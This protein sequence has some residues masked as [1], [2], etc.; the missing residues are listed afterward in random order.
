M[1]YDNF[2]TRFVFRKNFLKRAKARIETM[3]RKLNRSEFNDI[4]DLYLALNTTPKH[5]LDCGA[6]VGFITHIFNKKFPTANIHSFE[7]NPSVFDK[8]QQQFKNNTSVTAFNKGIGRESGKLVFNVNKNSGT[9]S[10]LNPN[11]Y[12]KQNFAKEIEQKEVEVVSI[13]DYIRLNNID[14][15][16][17]LKLDIE[18]FELEALKGIPNIENKVNIIYTEVNLVTTYEGQPLIEDIIIYLRGKG[19][20]ILNFY[21]INENKFHQ[22]TITNLVFISDSFKNKLK[23]QLGVKYF[24]Y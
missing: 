7:P 10:F 13:G 11:E 18:G 24:G 17:I 22:A 4:A 12:H 6:N 20:S 5:I 19:F 21:G 3:Y 1:F 16:D 14:M 23:E 8:L 9:S 2:F 15:I